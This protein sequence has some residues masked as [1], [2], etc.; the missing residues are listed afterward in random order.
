VSFVRRIIKRYRGSY[1]CN[2]QLQS[3]NV[4]THTKIGISKLI[5]SALVVSLIK[6]RGIEAL[7]KFIYFSNKHILY[8]Q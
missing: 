1:T 4:K 6:D 5:V 3:G 7:K 8:Y 2:G